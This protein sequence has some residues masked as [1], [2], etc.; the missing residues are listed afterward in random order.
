MLSTRKLVTGVA[1]GALALGL[2]FGQFMNFG[3]GTGGSVGITSAPSSTQ[4]ATASRTTS[5][6]GRPRTQR[7]DIT[8]VE[9]DAQHL[10]LVRITGKSYSIAEWQGNAADYRA[11]TA[12]E[13]ARLATQK[14]GDEKG[15]KVRISRDDSSKASAED[16]LRRELEAAGVPPEAIQ[17]DSG[18]GY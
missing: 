13:I 18:T 16:A 4:T 15:V 17:W 1:V 9:G 8:G 12:S 6:S 10:V 7:A 11:A 14:D 5:S 2:F 3:I